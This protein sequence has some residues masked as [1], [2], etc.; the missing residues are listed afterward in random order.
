[1][2]VIGAKGFAKEIIEI[3]CQCNQAEKL[4]FYDGVTG[5]VTDKLYDKFPVLKNMEE[6]AMYLSTVD[7]RFT[8]GI[9]SPFLI[10]K[11]YDQFIRKGGNFVSTISPLAIVGAFDVKIG[12]GSNILAKAIISNG[13]V[14]GK[15]CIV[16]YNSVITHD[17]TI[18]DFVEIS[19]AAVILGRCK[20]GAFVQIG[21]NATILPDIKLGQNVIIGAGAVVTKDIP[22]NCMAWGV[23]AEIK[24][25]LSPLH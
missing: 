8:I 18:G 3:I 9:G 19:P 10:K 14:L 7:N 21:A 16:Y 13:V 15:G 25:K 1:M 4:A 24:K 20:I 12:E 23:P 2:L 6:A 22:D 11:M 17:C 5:G